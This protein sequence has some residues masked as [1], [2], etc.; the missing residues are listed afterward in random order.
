MSDDHEA[1]LTAEEL[2]HLEMDARDGILTYP[3]PMLRLIAQ[4]RRALEVGAGVTETLD[5]LR[6]VERAFLADASPRTITANDDVVYHL[7]GQ[8]VGA[9][10]CRVRHLIKALVDRA[11][12]ASAE[13]DE[14][15]KWVTIIDNDIHYRSTPKPGEYVEVRFKDG[16]LKTG[17][18]RQFC[19]STHEQKAWRVIPEP[20]E[21]ASPPNT[22]WVMVPREPTEAMLARGQDQAE[23]CTD[24]FTARSGC[25]PEHVW[26][27]MIAAAPPSPNPDRELLEADELRDALQGCW[28]ALNF[29]LAFYEPGQR[30]LDTEAWKNAEASGRSAHKKAGE[31]LDRLRAA[32]ASASSGEA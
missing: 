28:G 24:D 30:Y 4:A 1:P 25:I 32:I 27:A 31:L 26:S 7:D 10:L 9:A 14:V 22:D 18:G 19:F 6:Q 23:E 29:I 15:G 2:V 3:V 20:T 21:P 11:S 5:C 13:S 17:Y 8:T 16:S 12:P